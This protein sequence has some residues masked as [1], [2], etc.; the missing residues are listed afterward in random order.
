MP[1]ATLMVLREESSPVCGLALRPGGRGRDE[2][3]PGQQRLPA[4]GLQLLSLSGGH[5]LLPPLQCGVTGIE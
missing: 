4:L 3:G 5:G 1:N 2:A